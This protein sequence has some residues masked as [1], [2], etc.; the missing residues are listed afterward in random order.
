[1]G[2]GGKAAEPAQDLPIEQDS[3]RTSKIDNGPAIGCYHVEI[4][5]PTR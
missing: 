4:Q 3:I 1:M 5:T 2:I